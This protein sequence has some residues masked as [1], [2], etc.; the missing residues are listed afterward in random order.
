MEQSFVREMTSKHLVMLSLGGVIG[1]GI[2]LSSGYLIQTT[3]SIGTIIAYLIGAFLVTLVM[4]C[5]GELSVHEPSTSS[6]HNYASKYI[7]PGAGFVVAWLYWL[8]WT[9]ALGSQFITLAILSQRWF[10]GIPAWIWCIF[11]IGIILLSN[12]IDVRWFSV[13]EFWM[14]L[15]KVLA[16]AIFLVLGLGGI[17]GFIPIQGNESA[18]LFSHL[19]EN[20]WFPKGAGS[21][22][23]AILSAN[24]A[25]SGAELIVVAAGET[26]D[27]KKNIPKAIL[28]TIVILVV[29]FIGT[30]VVI[31][32]LLPD[33]AANMDESPVTVI[34]NV[35]GIPYAADI[36][37]LVLITVV[38]SGANSGVYAASRMLW[39]LANAGTLPK[40]FAKLSKR[41]LPIY[42]LL[43]TI[44]GG[45][46]SLFSSIYSADTVYLALVSISAFAVVAV[47][48]SIAWAQLNFRKQYLKSGHKLDALD[49]K[50]PFYPI[51]PWLVIILCSVSIIGIAFDPNQRIAL[52]IGIPFT[53]LCFFYYQ[54]FF[55]K[56]ASVAVENQEVGEL[57]D[58]F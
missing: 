10:P 53:I 31:G 52:I 14:S 2:F 44:L 43:L 51:V 19:T 5:L 7:H 15:I 12:I 33:S 8:T 28:Q 47:W 38:L 1:T 22:F 29:L 35:M 9:V 18:P 21:V 13:S 45:L 6:F 24:F 26:S 50:T 25:F 55:S 54:L 56:K 34:L 57:S 3:G 32:A 40:R 20:G 36:M 41:G 17:F 4:M 30:I 42:G 16:L 27:P 37:N 58:G 11:Y 46:L 39:S 49:Y 48:L 23:L